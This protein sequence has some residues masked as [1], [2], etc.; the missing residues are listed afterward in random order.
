[1]EDIPAGRFFLRTGLGRKSSGSYYTPHAFVRFLVQE[2]L[3]PQV[4][5]HS[6]SSDPQPLR[7]LKLKVLDPAMGSGHFLV[8]ACRFLGDALYEACRLCDERATAA[9]ES[10]DH[11]LAAE[12]RQRVAELPDPNDEL[13][14]WLPSRAPEGSAGG[15]SQQR[16]L[17]LCR[18]LV[19]VHCLYGVDK[20]RLAV[21]LAKLSLWL[22]SYA[23]GLP[24]TFLDHR[25]VCGDSLTGPLFEH[26]FT[27]P[28][29]GGPIGDDL[30]TRGLHE[31]LSAALGR[32]LE[33][34]RDL[35]ASVGKD[36]ADLERKATAKA[37]LDGALEPFRTLAAA[38]AG[39]VMLSD[40]RGDYAYLRA[41]KAVVE[42]TEV[43]DDHELTRMIEIGGSGVV[44]DLAFP[45]V[46]HQDGQPERS[47]GFHAVVGN[48]PWDAIQPYA[49]EFFATFDLQVLEAVTKRERIEAQARLESDAVIAQLYHRYA[50][51][52]KQSKQAVARKYQHVGI[53]ADGRP[54]G[55]V[56]DLWQAFAEA[57]T[58]LTTRRGRIGLVLPASFHSNQSATGIRKLYLQAGR[59]D[60]Y[61]SFENRRLLFE[62]HPQLKFSL[63][64][65]SPNESPTVSFPC[66]FY[67]H[68][69]GWLFEQREIPRYTVQFV[70]ATGGDHL[71]FLE[72]RSPMDGAVAQRLYK[73][74]LP[75]AKTFE[76]MGLECGVGLD[77]TK[78]SHL[79]VDASEHLS[80]D[81]DPRLPTTAAMLFQS[82]LLPLHEGKTFH[83]YTDAWPEASIRYLVRTDTTLG[84]TRTAGFI[85]LAIR[86][87]TNSEN[88]R[89]AIAALLPPSFAAN[90]VVVEKAPEAVPSAHRLLVVA[91]LNSF[92]LDW[93]SRL[94][95]TRHLNKYILEA[96]PFPRIVSGSCRRYLVHSA[97]RL[98]CN[99]EGYTSL[100]LE[101]F[102]DVWRERTLKHSWPVLAGDDARWIVRAAI[103]AVVANAYGL[104]R[105]QYTHVL[106]S[107]SHKSYLPA[108]DLCLAAF[109][110]L[111]SVGLDAFVSKHDPYD[112]VPLNGALPKPVI[113][114]GSISTSAP[115]GEL[116]EEPR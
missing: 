16:A 49:K 29:A 95:V 116:F 38:W 90:T 75:A 104:S 96:L 68:E 77:M 92:S 89:T 81:Q 80:D 31:R 86:E 54:S 1:V 99:H 58:E 65:A 87:V 63:V 59:I 110:E 45:E 37:R 101:Q 76:A 105:E 19:A 64:V 85:R 84:H 47:G 100:W 111:H 60:Y 52:V 24:L 73:P 28:K 30:F 10:G 21:E 114:F 5:E 23:E 82:G 69:T 83:Q 56:I 15:L 103:D 25:L 50:E 109:D 97:L 51:A 67:A 112:D 79:F 32:A 107:F 12:F 72:L 36:V 18:R 48:P 33:G 26:L 27:W 8:E 22:E 71:T 61:F 98:S 39:A 46:F 108:P 2:T 7:I 43:P 88:E 91:V 4:A 3:G 62:A 34:V 35:T 20:N 53:Q 17:S 11:A 115:V 66:T 13:L 57:A 74:S 42:G 94:R 106:N 44:Y 9:N 93:A 70:R 14:E 40:D 55:A 41:A 6:P 78:A 113:H 102:G